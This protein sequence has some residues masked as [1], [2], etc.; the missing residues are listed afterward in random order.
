MGG[1]KNQRNLDAELDDL[2]DS[3][4]ECWRSAPGSKLV[5]VLLRY[6][7]G[8]NVYGTYHIVHIR[9]DASGNVLAVW[10]SHAVLLN[11][12]RKHRPKPGQR[13]G[14]KRLGDS[15]RG[16]ACYQMITDDS[17]ST[18]PDFKDAEPQ[19][20]QMDEFEALAASSSEG[21]DG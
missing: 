18:V 16:Y 10:L 15:N 12:F 21:H 14:I 8:T 11:E 13:V 3:L 17:E 4:P 9:D 5:G 7:R 19:D 1:T 20:M 2:G 6:D